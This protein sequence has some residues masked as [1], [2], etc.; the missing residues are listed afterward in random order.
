MTLH[1]SPTPDFTR[2]TCPAALRDRPQIVM[3]HGGGGALSRDLIEHVF[4]PAFGNPVLERL[5]DSSVLDVPGLLA[6]GGRLAFSTDSYVVRPLVFPGGSIG[7]L[8]VHGTVNDLAMSGAQ[9]LYL[10]A[11]FIL[12]EG[13]PITE[14]VGIVN[15]MAAAARA[16]GVDI[17]TGDTKVVERG[18]GDG[19]YINTAGIGV[20]PPGIDLGP[21]QIRPGD[22]L[23]VSGT[24]GD[25]GMAIM[26]VRE[27]LEFEAAIA[28]DTAPLHGLVA[29][30]LTACPEIRLLR[31][32]TRG[33]VA[34]SLNEI[35]DLAKLGLEID[36]QAIPVTPV[37]A[38]ACEILG[39]DPL[40]VANEGKLLAV[41]PAEA[42][43]AVLAAMRA[44][45]YGRE[46]TIL[47]R[48]V[49]D[50]PRLVVVRT[51]IGG[52][53]VVPMPIG[54]QLPRIC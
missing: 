53:R 52:T 42:A 16:A 20:V 36:E 45:A 47:G 50:H 1:G 41:V 18:H 31:D 15:R 49:A 28:S 26:S 14:L 10:S 9:P 7:D 19:V 4:L 48:V 17:V 30:M 32:P 54:E 46:A 44:H 25:H 21:H 11:G 6:G 8:A 34:T 51:A 24:L 22:A 3:G 39:L 2:F 5:G 43:E 33:G 12:E 38:N 35:A 13:L 27:G 23:L 40:Q 37:V 29:R